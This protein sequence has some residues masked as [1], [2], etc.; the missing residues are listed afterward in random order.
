MFVAASGFSTHLFRPKA[1]VLLGQQ[2][3]NRKSQ[4]LDMA[5]GLLPSS[6]VSTIPP[7]SFTDDNKILTLVG[8]A[9]NTSGE[10]SANAIVG[11]V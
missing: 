7:E 8:A 3:E 11:S 9:L 4:I 10:L 2:A 1:V 6:A 5:E